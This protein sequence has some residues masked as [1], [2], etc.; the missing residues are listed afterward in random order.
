M[1]A[2]AACLDVIMATE[3]HGT[4]PIWGTSGTGSTDKEVD[5]EIKLKSEGIDNGA[6]MRWRIQGWEQGTEWSP[7]ASQE[8][9]CVG[10][11][12]QGQSE[13]EHEPSLGLGQTYD[14]REKLW[15]EHRHECGWQKAVLEKPP[16]RAWWDT[17]N[18]HQQ[19]AAAGRPSSPRKSLLDPWSWRGEG[20]GE[21]ACRGALRSCW[22][23]N[24]GA[25]SEE[26]AVAL[27][28]WGEFA[29]THLSIM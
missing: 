29:R 9:S 22:R 15:Q 28:P 16:P 25:L 10:S 3:S 8:Y 24:S 14:G 4:S 20:A 19:E 5:R 2:G 6:W 17:W 11:P 21:R 18:G 12:L 27:T 1:V 7:P 26:T 13:V 23:S